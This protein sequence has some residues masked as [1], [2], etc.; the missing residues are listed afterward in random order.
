MHEWSFSWPSFVTFTNDYLDPLGIWLGLI[1]AV[2]IF[3]TWYQVTVGKQRRHRRWLG[4]R[5]A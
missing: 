2:P 3:G 1:L 4:N 5:S